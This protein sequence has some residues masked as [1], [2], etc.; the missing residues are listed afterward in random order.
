ML[1]EKTHITL[2]RHTCT[3]QELFELLTFN[4][5]LQNFL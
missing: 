5:D 2:Y 1:M 3:S 4:T